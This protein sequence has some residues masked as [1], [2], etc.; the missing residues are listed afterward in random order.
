[1]STASAPFYWLVCDG[2]GEKSTESSDYA[3][4]ADEGE[5]ADEATGNGWAIHTKRGDG[6]VGDWCE[7][8]RPPL[9]AGCGESNATTEYDD[10]TWCDECIADE[11][12]GAES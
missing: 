5:A 8:C 2:C 6:E 3:A 12:A 10:D 4:W 9:C 7:E 1:V 11:V